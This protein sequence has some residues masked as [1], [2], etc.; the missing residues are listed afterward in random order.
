[1]HEIDMMINRLG[2]SE[3]IEWDNLLVFGREILKTLKHRAIGVVRPDKPYNPERIMLPEH[4]KAA[5]AVPHV[6]DMLNGIQHQDRIRALEHARKA[7]E[8]LQ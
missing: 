2:S 5:L 6:E 8:V 4:H 1:M 3:R 7:R